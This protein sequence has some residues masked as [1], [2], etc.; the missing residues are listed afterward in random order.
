M[1][2]KPYE[3]IKK[4]ST[5]DVIHLMIANFEHTEIDSHL[6]DIYYQNS[7]YVNCH[8]VLEGRFKKIDEAL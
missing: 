2:D 8:S 5:A 7:V 6:K 1:Y 3:E 4:L